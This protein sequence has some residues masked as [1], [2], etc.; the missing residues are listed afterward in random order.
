MKVTVIG[1][2]HVEYD[3]KQ[4]RHIIGDKLYVTFSEKGTD[5]VA[6]F[7]VFLSGSEVIPSIGDEIILYYNRYGRCV[8]FDLAG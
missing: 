1:I 5:G 6:S 2:R 3:N 4:G 8:G 7:D